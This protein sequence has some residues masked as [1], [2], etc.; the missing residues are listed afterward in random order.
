MPSARRS[1]PRPRRPS[2]R[3][4]CSE[5]STCALRNRYVRWGAMRPD[6]LPPRSA[7]RPYDNAVSR[8]G[9]STNLRRY[10]P[11]REPGRNRAKGRSRRAGGGTCYF[12]DRAFE[13]HVKLLN[14]WP[15][16]VVRVSE[17]AHRREATR[18]CAARRSEN[19]RVLA[20]VLTGLLNRSS[21]A[22]RLHPDLLDQGRPAADRLRPDRSR[23]SRATVG[24][25]GE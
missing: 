20:R 7:R 17:R 16:A 5:P 25:S 14:T 23:A 1:S 11:P 15:R 13:V 19:R 10:S 3:R 9:R 24:C 8:C 6:L 18:S 2:R 12:E 4:V 21:G 22:D